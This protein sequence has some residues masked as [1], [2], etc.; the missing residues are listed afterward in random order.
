MCNNQ[1]SK[2]MTVSYGVPQGSILGP[3]LF[4]IY[5]NDLLYSMLDH[6]GVN[7]EMYADDTVLYVSDLCPKIAQEKNKAVIKRLHSWCVKNKLTINFKK[8]KH[9]VIHRDSTT[10][11]DNEIKIKVG[12][13]YIENVSIY[14]YLGVD[15]DKGLTYNKI[16]DSMFIYFFFF[17]FIE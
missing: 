13:N 9:M 8:T 12:N 4:I 16:L 5:V 6:P 10:T 17:F 3:C 1:I 11:L 15:L 7:I 2:E 14:H